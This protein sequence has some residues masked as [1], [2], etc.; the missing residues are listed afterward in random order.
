MPTPPFPITITEAP[1]T[2]NLA[3]Q[4]CLKAASVIFMCIATNSSQKGTSVALDI[5]TAVTAALRTLQTAT[6]AAYTT[7]TILQLRTASLNPAFT[8]TESWFQ[9]NFITFCLHY[10]YAD[11]TRACSLLASTSTSTPGLLDYIFVDPPAIHSPDGTARTG[12]KLSTTE[13]TPGVMYADLGAAFCEVAAR[14]AEF[15]GRA[16]L[17]GSVGVV[18]ETWGVLA[19]Y[20]AA[21]ARGRVWG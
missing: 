20:L 14:R 9:F 11:L 4:T 17:V 12:Y 2:D 8:A 10:L 16:V 13:A 19:G 6:G 15:S 21:G 5:A 18:T 7:P 3:L 1:P